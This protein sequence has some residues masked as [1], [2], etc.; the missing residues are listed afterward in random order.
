MKVMH[1][2]FFNDTDSLSGIKRYESELYNRM[3]DKVD[4]SR[5]QRTKRNYLFD[6][7]Q[8]NNCDIVHATFQELAPLLFKKLDKFILTVHDIIPKIY[9]SKSM[10][11]KHMW[12]LTELS[13]RLINT[14]IVDSSYTKRDLITRLNIDS[15]KIH[16]IPLGVSSQ[17]HVLNKCLSKDLFKLSPD[18][19]HILIVSS[20]LP[21]KNIHTIEKITDEM[22]QYTF[23][24]IG[25]GTTLDKKNVINLGYVPED[26]MPYLYNACDILLHPSAYEGFG[27]PVL[28]AMSCGCPVICSNSTALPELVGNAGILID[29]FDV[30]GYCDAIELLLSNSHSHNYKMQKGLEQALNFTWEQTVSKTFEVYEKCIDL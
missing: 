6:N 11:M 2:N 5:F 4:L 19:Q 1:W 18:K 3:V 14:I 10:K 16:I 13:L 12:Y 7:F 21:W 22:P 26:H 25:Y 30:A 24:K 28:E 9:Y 15:D 29:T 27:L 23:V 8:S 17:Y 20:N